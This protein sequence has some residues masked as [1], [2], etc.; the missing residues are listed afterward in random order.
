MRSLD[1][2]R[3]IV[4]GGGLAGLATAAYLA[5]DGRRVT[6]LEKAPTLGGRAATDLHHGFALNRGAHGLYTGGAAS[7][8]LQDLGVTYPHGSPKH[9]YAL[10]E[11]GLHPFPAAAGALLTT[12]LL[13]A[14]E[15]FE[16]MRVFARVPGLQP[17]QFAQQSVADFLD[18]LT[19][20]PRIHALLTTT[21]RVALYTCALDLVS[22]DL[23]VDRLQQSIKYPIHYVEGGWRTLVERLQNVAQTS[24]VEIR[25]GSGV[26]RVDLVEGQ[27]QGVT[28]HDGTRLDASDVVLAVTPGDALGLLQG[29]SAGDALQDVLV[30]SVPVPLACLDLA[31][32]RLPEPQHPVVLRIDAPHFATAQS[33]FT[34]LAPDGAAVIHTMKQLDPRAESDPHRD[35]ADL[36]GF[37]DRIQ[38]GWRE[39]VI[40]HRF[41]PHISAAGLLPLA[42]NGGMAGRPKHQSPVSPNLFFVGDW[43]GPEGWLLD[44]SLS[45]AR[46][47]AKALRTAQPLVEPAGPVTVRSVRAA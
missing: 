7:A 29:S 25:A 40:E 31:L 8:V 16:L 28:L 5:R 11:R 36:E 35:R 30:D 14:A 17:K 20:S 24:G 44:A 23:F 1:T 6:V 3:T 18:R 27:V 46:A 19:R 33:E 21:A 12:S 41:L 15:K 43:V 45:S 34:R 9:V 47:V 42:S 4:V 39:L 38:P 37:V 13:S 10:D 22:A 2:S 32:S 26:A